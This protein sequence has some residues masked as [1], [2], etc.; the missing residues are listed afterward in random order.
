MAERFVVINYFQGGWL[1]G[2]A[3]GRPGAVRLFESRVATG[4]KL[5]LRGR[6]EL[7]RFLEGEDRTVNAWAQNSGV[8]DGRWQPESLGTILKVDE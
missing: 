1:I 4:T 3:E 7:R 5:S 6:D 2:V 8:I